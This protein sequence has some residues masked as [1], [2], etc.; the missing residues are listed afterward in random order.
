MAVGH[1]VNRLFDDDYVRDQIGAAL[2]SGRRAYRRARAKKA[3]DAVKDQRLMDHLTGAARSL[4]AAVRALT[5][6]PPPKPKRRPLKT[7]G[8]LGAAL[9]VGAAAA[10][11]D[12]RE[13]E[14]A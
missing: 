1:Y 9:A 13:A 5:D 7:A 8:L 12:S 10:W 11:I 4:Q 3:A 6:Q 14:P 2:V